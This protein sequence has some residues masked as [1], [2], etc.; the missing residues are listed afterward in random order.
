M[1]AHQHRV[2]LVLRR[3]RDQRS[4]TPRQ[5]VY[6]WEASP[7]HMVRRF[8]SPNNPEKRSLGH[9]IHL[10]QAP[11]GELSNKAGSPRALSRHKNDYIE[12][13][14]IPIAGVEFSGQQS[15][16][17]ESSTDTS[18]I[19]PCP[20]SKIIFSSSNFSGWESRRKLVINRLD[21]C[22]G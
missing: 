9:S 13:H 3:V 22:T 20:R 21:G 11:R 18:G 19:F 10:E 16:E 8:L 7:L 4:T 12:K 2:L 5:P 17:R 15:A 1:A 14:A 6:L